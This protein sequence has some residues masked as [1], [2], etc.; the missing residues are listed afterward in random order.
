MLSNNCAHPAPPSTGQE[1]AGEP[2]P[3]RQGQDAA[4]R[5]EQLFEGRSTLE[6]EHEGCRYFLRATRSGKLILTK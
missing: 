4:I 5:S 2:L 3:H 6:I 1:T